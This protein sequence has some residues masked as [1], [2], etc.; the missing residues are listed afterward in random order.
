MTA[1]NFINYFLLYLERSIATATAIITPFITCCHIGLTAINC[2]PYCITVN[3]K[4]PL[5]I[6][7]TLPTP[8]LRETPPTTQAAMASSSYPFPYLLVAP[9]VLAAYIIPPTAYKNDAKIN[10]PIIVANT[11]TPDTI[12]ASLFPPIA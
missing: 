1:L 5:T 6:P 12:A 2:N 3:I 10:I 7:P 9:S 8:P 11:F 4:T